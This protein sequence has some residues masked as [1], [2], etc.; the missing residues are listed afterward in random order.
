MMFRR[1]LRVRVANDRGAARVILRRLGQYD[2]CGIVVGAVRL[3]LD[4]ADERLAD[5]RMKA[6]DMA[7]QLNGLED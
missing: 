6:A 7:R 1:K 3:D 5:L 4:D 2:N